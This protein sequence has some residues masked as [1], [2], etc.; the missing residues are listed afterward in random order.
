MTL[1]GDPRRSALV[2]AAGR[3]H[4]PTPGVDSGTAYMLGQGW[5]SGVV[6]RW[7]SWAGGKTATSARSFAA[8]NARLVVALAVSVCFAAG[9]SPAS[10]QAPRAAAGALTEKGPVADSTV[11]GARGWA[12]SPCQQAGSPMSAADRQPGCE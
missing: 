7:G 9:A 8:N 6:L 12:L 4:L 3:S 10:P 2:R 1:P 11:P 5:P